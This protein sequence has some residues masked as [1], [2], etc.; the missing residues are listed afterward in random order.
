MYVCLSA[1]CVNPF[2]FFTHSKDWKE[3]M[4]NEHGV[5]WFQTVHL[6]VWYC[7]IKHDPRED[8]VNILDY[9]SHLRDSH[10]LEDRRIDTYARRKRTHGT[11]EPGVCPLCEHHVQQ[12][13]QDQSQGHGDLLEHIAAHLR[14]LSMYS[15]PKTARQLDTLEK[16]DGRTPESLSLDDKCETD[17]EDNAQSLSDDSTRLLQID[18]VPEDSGNREDVS[19]RE[20]I[21][22]ANNMMQLMMRE[23]LDKKIDRQSSILPDALKALESDHREIIRVLLQPTNAVSADYAF[24]EVHAHARELQRRS[25]IKRWSWN[26]KGRQMYLFEQADK[27]V[28]LLD[29]FKTV[30]DIVAN[31]D[32]VHV[33]L[34][35]AG[36]RVILEVRIGQ[37][38]SMW[39]IG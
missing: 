33:D 6:T 22:A 1:D 34:P 32:P 10:G 20:E 3:H 31:V 39:H 35:W 7:D 38:N 23:I 13:S 19:R 12:N 8:F 36:V 11:R 29:R 15:L 16:L 27:V 5:R 24:D 30:G 17:P 25:K 21:P 18:D 4:M 26:Y 37:R 9:R 14:S 2:Q 28:R